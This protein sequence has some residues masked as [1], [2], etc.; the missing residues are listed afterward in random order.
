MLRDTIRNGIQS[1]F[2]LLL[3]VLITAAVIG[4]AFWLGAND[5]ELCRSEGF[6]RW[7]CYR[8]IWG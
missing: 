8:M 7:Y 2:L 3:V 6:S 4:L 1:V 5:Y